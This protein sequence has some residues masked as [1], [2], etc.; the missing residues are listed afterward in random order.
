M[1]IARQK[2]SY[3]YACSLILFF[4]MSD[5]LTFRLSNNII[6]LGSILFLVIGS[7]INNNFN[8]SY[9]LHCISI[10]QIMFLAYALLTCLY[11][12]TGSNPYSIVKRMIVNIITIFSIY[13]T[14]KTSDDILFVLNCSI[15]ALVVNTIYIYATFG[16]DSL[17][18]ERLGLTV[19]NWNSNS[20]GLMMSYGVSYTFL[21]IVCR[22]NKLFVNFAYAVLMV[23][24]LYMSL[25]SGSKKAIFVIIATVSIY[26]LINKPNRFILNLLFI[27]LIL[28][29]AYSLVMHN[30]IIYNV[31][32]KRIE[33]MFNAYTGTAKTDESTL[34]RRKFIEI[35]L[36]I[37]KTS[38]LFGNG[39]NSFSTFNQLGVYSHNNFVEILCNFGIFG[40]VLYY[41]V[42]VKTAYLMWKARKNSSITRFLLSMLIVDVICHYGMVTYYNFSSIFI[43][44]CSYATTNMRTKN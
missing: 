32:G 38:P 28:Y 41:F 2:T 26:I 11:T 43:L 12:P 19:E 24:F 34:L 9:K 18:S 17:G 8:F 15:I 6:W 1:I 20:I 27:L 10:W 44:G 3:F 21:M 33:L 31:L 39:L 14:L 25:L 5:N 42:Y 35:G 4:I 37:F 36:R 7:I 23:L 22:K 13:S 40:F 30:S 16:A 29:A